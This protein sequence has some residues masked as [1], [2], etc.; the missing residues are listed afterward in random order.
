[1]VLSTRQAPVEHARRRVA[2]ILEPMHRVARDEYDG[3][4]AGCRGL[5]TDGQLIGTLQDEE[6]FFLAKMNMVGWAFTGFVPRHEDRDS[7]AGGLSGKE[8]FH[9]EAERLDRQ[10]L[11][12]LDDEGLQ[13]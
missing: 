5:A 3:T 7:A 8:Y 6:H 4:G 1:M 2:D 9:V 12:G 11:F 13:G 10:R